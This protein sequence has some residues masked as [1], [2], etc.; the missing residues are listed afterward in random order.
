MK[1]EAARRWIVVV[2]D[3]LALDTMVAL[4]QAFSKA[5]I[6]PF[7]SAKKALEAFI[8]AP[9]SIHLV[10]TDLDVPNMNSLDLCR[11]LHALAPELKVFLLTADG[12]F[13]EEAAFRS[14]FCGLLRKPFTLPALKHAIEQAQSR[15]VCSDQF[16]GAFNN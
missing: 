9:E 12:L 1:N 14:G 10:I 7:R 13:S 5:E 15:A 8:A 6:L 3:E 16:S 4:L 2:D 11:N